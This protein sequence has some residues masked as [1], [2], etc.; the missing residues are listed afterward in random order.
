MKARWAVL[1]AR[2]DALQSRE[3]YLVAFAVL[4]GIVLL[5]FSLLVEPAMKRG[6][7]AE[8]QAAEQGAQFAALQAQIKTLQ[9]PGRDPDVQARAELSKLK[10]QLAAS[11]E[12]LAAMESSLVPPQRMTALLEDMIGQVSGL[13]LLSLRTLPVAPLIGAQGTATS[14]TGN[15]EP[16]EVA[17]AA[18]SDK[19]AAQPNV[20]AGGL[21]Q[22]G[23][24]IRLEGSYQQLTVY[25]Q[26]LEKSK[27]KLLWSRVSLAAED[28]P[29]LVLTLTVYTISLDRAWLIV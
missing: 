9:D 8:R 25:L 20:L 27:T 21:Y 5:G 7:L 12:Q 14:N 17:N 15:A 6:Q 4:A 1:A 2:F 22:H 11:A 18:A 26:S 16:K 29:R 13:Q 10:E 19:A 23:V 24:E 3:R 28:H